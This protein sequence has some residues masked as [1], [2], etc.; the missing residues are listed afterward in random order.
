[1]SSM[2]KRRIGEAVGILLGVLLICLGVYLDYEPETDPL[3]VLWAGGE[4]TFEQAIAIA[5]RLG[6]ILEH[7]P[8]PELGRSDWDMMALVAEITPFYYYEGI[9]DSTRL[10]PSKWLQYEDEAHFHVAGRYY[11]FNGLV[12]VNA[13]HVNPYS[14]KWYKRSY[15]ATLVHEIGHAE[16]ILTGSNMEATNQLATLEVLAAMVRDQ[17]VY[18]LPAFIEALQ[19]YAESYAYSL[20]IQNGRLGDYMKYVETRP[21]GVWSLATFERSLDHWR[22]NWAELERILVNYGQV[23]FLFVIGALGDADGHTLCS[24]DALPNDTDCLALNDTA[25]VLKNLSALLLGYPDLVNGGGR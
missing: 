3:D 14:P 12:T 20:A 5:T 11:G 24:L 6:G 15:L 7:L 23:P 21:G 19:D 22:Q 13:R 18:A 16:G 4:P 25:W 1:M 2:A 17:N 10:P 8:S 9:T